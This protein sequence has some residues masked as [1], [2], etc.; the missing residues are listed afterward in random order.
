MRLRVFF[1]DIVHVISADELDAKLFMELH[2]LW[3]YYLVLVQPMILKLQIKVLPEYLTQCFRLFFC[4]VIVTVKK[5]VLD[6]IGKAGMLIK[7]GSELNQ[8]DVT[9]VCVK[10]REAGYRIVFSASSFAFITAQI[11]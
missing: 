2:Q 10:I 3:I 7:S 11:A 8:Q 4:S 6:E 5:S 9:S 1:P